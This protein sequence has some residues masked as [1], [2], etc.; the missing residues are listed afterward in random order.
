MFRRQATNQW[1]DAFAVQLRLRNVPG[2][3]IGEAL[4]EVDTHCADAGQSPQEAFGDP[5]AYAESL[6]AGLGS[7]TTP[8]TRLSRKDALTTLSTLAGIACLLEGVDSVTHHLPG[9]LTTGHL[10]GV[11]AGTAGVAAIMTVLFR[12]SHRRGTWLLIAATAACV[13]AMFY[14][15]AAWKTPLVHAPGWLLLTVGVLALAVAWFPLV[16]GRLLADRIV[17][18]R[19]GTEPY[20]AT[21]LLLAIF[22]WGLPALLLLAVAL[23]VMLPTPPA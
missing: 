7:P 4:A 18:P 11:V 1:R 17:D 20:P 15:Q 3:R 8:R 16:S 10:A 9:I 5:Q 22:R 12:T 21:R 2:A 14:V 6:A 19:T 13:S 23:I